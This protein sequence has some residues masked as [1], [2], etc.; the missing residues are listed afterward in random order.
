MNKEYN[1]ILTGVINQWN[2]KLEDSKFSI[3]D[4]LTTGYNGM[5][6]VTTKLVFKDFLTGYSCNPVTQEYEYNVHEI[7]PEDRVHGHYRMFLLNLILW[8]TLYKTNKLSFGYTNNNYMSY[9]FQDLL[10]GTYK[11]VVK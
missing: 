10:Y 11:E 8:S 7:I 9:S 5:I 1:A 6:H 2:K 4:T 3:E